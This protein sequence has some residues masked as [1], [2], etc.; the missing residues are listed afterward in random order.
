MR[1]SNQLVHP[2]VKA[3]ALACPHAVRWDEGVW[4]HSLCQAHNEHISFVKLRPH[5]VETFIHSSEVS[6][7]H[8]STLLMTHNLIHWIFLNKC[9]VGSFIEPSHIQFP[10]DENVQRSQTKG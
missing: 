3:V 6:V 2:H 1:G 8:S 9:W 10:I 7:S 5:S 4:T